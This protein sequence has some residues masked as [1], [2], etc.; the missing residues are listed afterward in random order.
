[1]IMKNLN[2]YVLGLVLLHCVFLIPVLRCNENRQIESFSKFVTQAQQGEIW[3]NLRIISNELKDRSWLQSFSLNMA[4][5]WCFFE[6]MWIRKALER[7][8][9]YSTGY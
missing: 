5:F 3:E 1:M 2:S 4:L 6:L 7:M 9:N 8:S